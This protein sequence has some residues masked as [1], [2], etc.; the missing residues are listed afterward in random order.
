[1]SGGWTRRKVLGAA[2][3]ATPLGAALAGCGGGGDARWAAAGS[4]LGPGAP[5]SKGASPSPTVNSAPQPATAA[6]SPKPHYVPGKCM[7]GAYLDL[8]GVNQSQALTLRHQ[9][10]GRDLPIWHNYWEWADAM[11]RKSPGPAGT[12][13]LISWWGIS[14]ATILNGS[15]DAVIARAADSLAALKQPV[16]LRWAWEMN[17]NWY[18][19]DG[20]HNGKDPNS[21]IQAWRRL[22]SIFSQHRAVN[23]GWVWG[24]NVGSLP[25]DPWNDMQNYYPGDDYVDWI[26][27]S[28]YAG[29]RDTAASLFQPFT[30]RYKTHKP[31]MIAETG[32]EEHGGTV[33]ADWIRSLH[34][35]L[36]ANPAVGAMV[37]FDTDDD[38]SSTQ[39]WRI[40]SSPTALA[41]FRDMVNDPHFS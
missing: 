17:G 13:P 19:W 36:V 8:K 39:N 35:W 41:A 2:A 12:T 7:L 31:I 18:P 23:V 16:F 32:I 10:L 38:R 11:P 26:A 14:L 20:M 1:V 30:D 4:T 25:N 28:A 33:K 34:S 22:H 24:P 21:Y 29:G 37:W 9:Q 5:G 40:D 27:V 6:D 3:L 15:Q